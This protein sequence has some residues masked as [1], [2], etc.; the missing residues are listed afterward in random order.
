MWLWLLLAS[1]Q[2]QGQRNTGQPA[3]AFMKFKN[4]HDR[5]QFLWLA[6]EVSEGQAQLVSGAVFFVLRVVAIAPLVGVVR[7]VGNV[8]RL[9]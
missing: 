6:S 1:S 4:V 7:L 9:E 3:S 2:Q 8:L 5:E